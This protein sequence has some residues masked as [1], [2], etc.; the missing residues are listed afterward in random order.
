MALEA[1]QLFLAHTRTLQAQNGRHDHIAGG[2]Q[3]ALDCTPPHCFQLDCTTPRDVSMAMQNNNTMQGR[4]ACAIQRGKALLATGAH[5]EA[6]TALEEAAARA[7]SAKLLVHEVCHINH[8]A[9]VASPSPPALPPPLP[10]A[11]H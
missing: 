9:R 2:A 1:S 8:A 5:E 11:S 3:K 4:L 7:A 6:A 10:R